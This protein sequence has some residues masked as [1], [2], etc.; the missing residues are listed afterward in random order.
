MFRTK[1]KAQPQHDSR[2]ETSM[3]S[4]NNDTSLI[5][6]QEMFYKPEFGGTS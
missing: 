1:M 4:S 5:N 3:N 2:I 6:F